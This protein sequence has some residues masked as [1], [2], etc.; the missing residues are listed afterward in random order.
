MKTINTLVIILL[1]VA[2]CKQE[3][4][5]APVETLKVKRAK[6][7]NL[8]A[9]I[10]PIP[11]Y[12]AGRVEALESVK[13]SFK[14]GGIVKRL[15]VDV[16]DYVREGQVIGQLDLQEINAQ[17]TQAEANVDK[18]RRDLSRFRR[19]Y[20][21][22]AATLQ[23]VQDLE[24]GLSIAESSLRIATFNQAY[25]Q[26]VAPASGRIEQ[27]M[28]EAN[29]LVDPGQP[30]Y[31][32]STKS[33]GMSLTVGL[34][35]RDVVKL[36]LGD[37]A[38]VTFDAY[39]GEQAIAEVTEIAAQGHPVTGTFAVEMTIVSFPY[40]LKSGFFAKASI[41]PSRQEPYFK[42]PM[43]AV[44]EGSEDQVIIYTPEED[45]V[46]KVAVRPQYIGD[47]YFTIGIRDLT[48]TTAAVVTDGA[49]YLQEGE[50]FVS[51]D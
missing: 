27:R 44:V 37:A 17:V 31:F 18:L 25:S 24:T 28:A 47:D 30:I 12:A 39:P 16:G 38:A 10:E 20:V 4:T 14:T 7:V 32:L 9:T 11:V 45:K 13:L 51:I 43:H 22:S 40:E 21:D 33:G 5:E 46:K 2:G 26:I 49:A 3:Y 36:K 42:I 50:S 8:E 6:V 23:S 15:T 48:G 1:L 19:L 29:E 34:A 35:D 41:S